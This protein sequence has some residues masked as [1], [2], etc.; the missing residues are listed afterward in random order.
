MNVL[1]PDLAKL[2]LLSSVGV[3]SEK[4]KSLDEAK[5]ELSNLS[6][7]IICTGLKIEI[8]ELRNKLLIHEKLLRSLT[9]KEIKGKKKEEEEKK[10]KRMKK[11]KK[12]TKNMMT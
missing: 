6:C 8:E 11:K 9:K 12:K 5:V 2:W 10:G 3:R 7:Y 4:R 1:R